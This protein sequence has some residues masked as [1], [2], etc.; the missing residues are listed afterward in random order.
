MFRSC[1]DEVLAVGSDQP[2]I[3]LYSTATGKR[4]ASLEG[5][6][7][8]VKGLAMSPDQ[9]LLF[10]ASSDGCIKVWALSD[11]LVSSACLLSLSLLIKI[12]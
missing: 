1:K 6:S 3:L 9:K 10:S 4:L 7:S 5:H 12:K 2:V 11:T 8:R